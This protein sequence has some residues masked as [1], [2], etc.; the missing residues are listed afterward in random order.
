MAEHPFRLLE[1]FGDKSEE[2]SR[3]ASIA[4]IIGQPANPFAMDENFQTAEQAVPWEMGS[5]MPQS[6]DYY[7]K[8]KSQIS[9]NLKFQI[10]QREQLEKRHTTEYRNIMEELFTSEGHDA[11]YAGMGDIEKRQAIRNEISLDELIA[12]GSEIRW[13]QENVDNNIMQLL[14][15]APDEYL[16]SLLTTA[17]ERKLP[18]EKG[19]NDY[20]YS[21]DL[22]GDALSRLPLE[23]FD[24]RGHPVKVYPNSIYEEY[25][26]PES[27]KVAPGELP[28]GG[29]IYASSTGDIIG[30]QSVMDRDPSSVA[31][32]LMHEIGHQTGSMPE[33]H[34]PGPLL[35]GQ[36]QARPE[37]QRTDYYVLKEL[38]EGGAIEPTH[39][40]MGAVLRRSNKIWKKRDKAIPFV[41][42]PF[43]AEDPSKFFYD[44]EFVGYKKGTSKI[45]NRIAGQDIGEHGKTKFYEKMKGLSVMTKKERETILKEYG[46]TPK[47]IKQWE[48]Y[49]FGKDNALDANISHY[50]NVVQKLYDEYNPQLPLTLY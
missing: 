47:V 3:F 38:I 10:G 26:M 48:R 39:R 2:A 44:N 1:I 9:D 19:Y 29:D 20:R 50:E 27:H 36:H 35:P 31:F 4:Q 25:I 8:T 21:T 5:G 7:D 43:K 37:E 15:N 14:E 33:G 16:E 22:L 23:E 34:K 11:K 24:V 41:G 6:Q 12:K 40:D 28:S 17:A 45:A 42:G 32:T 18:K 49:Y 13:N 30:A 46:M